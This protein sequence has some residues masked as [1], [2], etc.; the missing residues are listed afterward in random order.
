MNIERSS[1]LLGAG[2]VIEASFDR[3]VIKQ[4]AKN[5]ACAN[6]NSIKSGGRR[7]FYNLARALHAGAASSSLITKLN[8]VIF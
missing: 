7:A 4:M 2:G 6:S 3:G 1:Y 8:A 5:L